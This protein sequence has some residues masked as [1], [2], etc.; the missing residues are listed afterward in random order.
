MMKINFLILMSLIFFG[1][2]KSQ[3]INS[4][5]VKLEFE[6]SDKKTENNNNVILFLE[7]GFD[8]YLKVYLNNKLIKEGDFETD[9]EYGTAGEIINYSYN[10]QPPIF[11]IVFDGKC[12]EFKSLKDYKIIFL[13]KG[14]NKWIV[15]YRNSF[16]EYE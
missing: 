11:K 5:N 4:C 12:L 13:H 3:N 6:F 14:D 16:N 2:C 10:K 1:S 8:D 7:T 15:E 9:R